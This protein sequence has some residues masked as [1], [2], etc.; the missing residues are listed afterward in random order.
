MGDISTSLGDIN[1]QKSII[2]DIAAAA[3]EN[4]KGKARLGNTKLR[5][6]FLVNDP[7]SSVSVCWED[8]RPYIKVMLI[9]RFGISMKTVADAIMEEIYSSVTEIVGIEP[10]GIKAVITGTESADKIVRREIEFEREG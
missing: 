4:Q 1:I 2:T 7:G 10:A 3:V 8:G 9:V 5:V 6:G